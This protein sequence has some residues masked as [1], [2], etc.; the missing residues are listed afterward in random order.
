M[1]A[2][3][4][5][6]HRLSP[7]QSRAREMRRLMEELDTAKAVYDGEAVGKLEKQLKALEDGNNS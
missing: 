4:H 6:I 1:C 7:E 3:S 2:T 5:Q